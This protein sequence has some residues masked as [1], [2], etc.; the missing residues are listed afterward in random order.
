MIPDHILISRYYCMHFIL[1]VLFTFFQAP[2]ALTFNYRNSTPS[3]TAAPTS[4]LASC[5][6]SDRGTSW[7]WWPGRVNTT[8]TAATVVYIVNNRTNTTTTSTIFND[9][10]AGYT[11]PPSNSAGSQI[12]VITVETTEGSYTST[13]LYVLALTELSASPSS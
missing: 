8:I 4:C 11:I 6:V 9:L 3:I 13:T 5:T 2:A 10:P 12:A 1:L 7:E